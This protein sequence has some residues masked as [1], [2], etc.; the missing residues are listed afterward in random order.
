MKDQL[1]ITEFEQAV[2][3]AVAHL[4]IMYKNNGGDEAQRTVKVLLKNIHK[5]SPYLDKVVETVSSSRPEFRPDAEL[6]RVIQPIIDA[7]KEGE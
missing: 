4:Y 1:T 3:N 5:I 2:D 6:F 7:L